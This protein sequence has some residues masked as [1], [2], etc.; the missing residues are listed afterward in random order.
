MV[1]LS[2]T[3]SLLLIV[4]LFDSSV[5][6]DDDSNAQSVLVTRD[7][8]VSASH[9]L[10]KDFPAASGDGQAFSCLTSSAAKLFNACT[11]DMPSVRYLSWG[12]QFLP[13]LLT[14]GFWQ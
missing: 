3:L 13:S 14:E 5:F 12:T 11:P 7:P 8:V 1:H 4:G 2:Q 10:V 6:E 9:Q